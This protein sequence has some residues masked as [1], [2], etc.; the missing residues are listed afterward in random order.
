MKTKIAA[1]PSNVRGH[2]LTDD[3]DGEGGEDTMGSRG[4]YTAAVIGVAAGLEAVDM[5]V[6]GECV[7]VFCAVRPPGHH[8]GKLYVH[9]G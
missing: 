1:L 6:N 8:A 3:S 5:V 2:P 7:N 4:S 9:E